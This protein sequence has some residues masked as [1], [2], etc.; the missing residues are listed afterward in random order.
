M[1]PMEVY[2]RIVGYLRPTRGWNDAMK[3]MF[4]DRKVY[5]VNKA[6]EEAEKRKG[7][8]PINDRE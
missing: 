3:A 7:M 2:S 8:M 6:V 4:Y 5:S 1:I